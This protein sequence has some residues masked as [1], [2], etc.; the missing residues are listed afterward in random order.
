VKY[1]ILSVIIIVVSCSEN[2]NKE[3]KQL[4]FPY[5]KNYSAT[6]YTKSTLYKEDGSVRFS[7]S[8]FL[9]LKISK[10]FPEKNKKI[11]EWLMLPGVY[12]KT[13]PDTM[14]TVID[15]SG[16]YTYYSENFLPG[17]NSEIELISLPLTSGKQWSSSY[18]SF[19]AKASYF[20]M[21]TIIKTSAGDFNSFAIK[22][23]FS[24]YYMNEFL[25]DTTNQEIRG[26]LVDYYSQ[27]AGKVLTKIDYYVTDKKSGKRQWKILSNYSILSK[28]YIPKE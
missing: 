6:Y 20:N 22:Y 15:S 21:D 1:L 3:I 7:D 19:P 2:K 8:T 11:F 17:A 24:P 23:E 26:L 13:I 5:K 25:S 18:L 16:L 9:N 12:D 28:L 27:D 14:V 10:Q 4:E